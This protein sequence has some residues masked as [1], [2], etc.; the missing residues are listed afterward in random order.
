MLI[1]VINAEHADDNHHRNGVYA[2]ADHGDDDQGGHGDHY[3]GGRGIKLKMNQHLSCCRDDD[4]F[5]VFDDEDCDD[6]DANGNGEKD[7]NDE[8]EDNFVVYDNDDDN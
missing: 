4:A 3:K 2:D 6:D 1:T 7:D 8:N 5:E